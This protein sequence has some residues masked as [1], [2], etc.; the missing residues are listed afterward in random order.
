MLKVA[1]AGGSGYAGCEL[2]RILISHKK[3]KIVAVTSERFRGRPVH[4]V[5]PNLKGLIDMDFQS[6]DPE[7]LS[8]SADLIFLALPHEASMNL[9]IRL[10][11]QGK[12]VIDLSAIFRL[13]N[14]TLYEEWY[15]IK[16]IRKD[17]VEKA[18]YGLTELNRKD[19]KD[20]TL[21][22]NPGCYPTVSILAVAPLIA[23][24]IIDINGIAIDAKSGVSGAG[25]KVEQSYLFS[26]VNEGVYAYSVVR[27]R[28]T[29]EIEQ[30]L[31]K[32][33]GKDM[34]V[35]FIPHIIPMD[36]GILC[37]IYANLVKG[38]S[39]K[40]L[41]TIYG[42]YYRDEPFI[43][44]CENGRY[45][46]TKHV[47]GSN[48]CDIGIKVDERTGRVVV[49]AAIDNLVKGASG[50]AVQNMNVMFGFE[51]TEGLMMAGVFP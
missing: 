9:G 12:H 31:G 1:V 32:I 42:K 29:P 5:Y 8:K 16:H 23:E 15:G 3:T 22:A 49:I 21:V 33:S 47:I 28:H 14:I 27:H 51:E 2:L 13:K 38:K 44:M 43:R 40:E 19:L 11:E 36:R 50:Q 24:G 7:V 37:T 39:T 26:E 48:Y 35:S 30:E 18:V 46:Y 34:R 41:L 45:P 17:V 6:A 10:W 4:E 25:R 20:A